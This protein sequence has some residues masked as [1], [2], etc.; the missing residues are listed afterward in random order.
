M[1]LRYVTVPTVHTYINKTSIIFSKAVPFIVFIPVT[2]IFR[3]EFP[4][5]FEPLR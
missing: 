5:R 3:I 1:F 4:F 2:S